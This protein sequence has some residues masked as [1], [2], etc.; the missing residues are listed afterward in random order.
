MPETISELFEEQADRTPEAIA[1][2]LGASQC[3]YREIDAYANQI[4]HVLRSLG[5]GRDVLVGLFLHRSIEMI[6]GMLG[7]LKAGGAYVPL[8]PAYPRQRIEFIARDANLAAIVTAKHLRGEL[9]GLLCKTICL[10]EDAEHISR[11]SLSRPASR[12]A[13]NDLAYVIYTSGSTGTPKGVLIEHRGVVALARAQIS[14]FDVRPDSRVLQLSSICFDASV[15][16]YLMAFATG[17]RL[18]LIRDAEKMPGPELVRLIADQQIT[19]ALLIPSTLAAMPFAPLPSL[20]VIVSAA[21]ACPGALVDRWGPGRKFVNA[22]G[23]TETTVHATAYDCVPGAGAPPIGVPLPGI[24]AHVLDENLQ[25]VPVGEVGEIHIGGISLARGYLGRPEITASRFVMNPRVPGERLYKSGDVGRMLSN[26]VIEYVG[27]LDQQVKIRGYR[28]ELGEIELALRDHPAVREA[29]AVARADAS[30]HKRI[31]AFVVFNAGERADTAGLRQF[32]GRRLPEYMIPAV[33][34][35]MDA[36][37]LAPS[38]KVDR[39]ALPVFNGIRPDTSSP[40]VVPRNAVEQALADIVGGVLGIDRAGCLDD[41]LEVGGDSLLAVRVVGRISAAFGVELRVRDVFLG[42]TIARMA[43]RVTELLSERIESRASGMV[44][45]ER[46][47][48][49][50]LSSAENRLWF[51]HQV[52][53]SSIAY[54][55]PFA[56][57]I[58]GIVDIDRLRRALDEMIRRHESLRT[59]YVDFE[60][61]PERIIAD[62]LLFS[63]DVIDSLGLSGIELQRELDIAWSEMAREA[64][65]LRLGPLFRMRLVRH[66]EHAATLL[67]VFH[68]LI[69]DGRSMAIFVHDLAMLTDASTTLP[70]VP[71]DYADYAFWQR[72]R[73]GAWESETSYWR[74][75]LA[76]AP[77]RS[78]LP[79]HWAGSS[80]S[81]RSAKRSW[82]LPANI[83]SLLRVRAREQ[84]ASLFMVLF[85][86][87]VALL[88]EWTG[89]NDILVGTPTAGR[90]IPE[91]ESVLGFFANTLVLR[92]RFAGVSTF[93]TLLANVRER[94][95][96]AYAHANVPFDKLVEA[97]SPARMTGRNPFF[98]VM[99]ALQ[100]PMAVCTNAEGTRFS[101][102]EGN[103]GDSPFDL[104]WQIWEPKDPSLPLTGEVTFRAD[105]ARDG[106]I[107][108][109]LER[110]TAL[111]EVMANTPDAPLITA[112]QTEV[113][114]QIEWA[115]RIETALR[116]HVGIRDV[117]VLVEEEPEPIPRLHLADWFEQREVLHAKASVAISPQALEDG[118][119][120]KTTALADG[121]PLDIAPDEPQTLP[122]A[123]VRAAQ[124]NRGLIYVEADGT[125]SQQSYAELLTEAR[126]LLAGLQRRG[127]RV[128]DRV[129]LQLGA[130]RAHFVSF[131]ACLLGGIIPVTV[132]VAP[133]Y[134]VSSG[135]TAKLYNVWKLLGKPIILSTGR[136]A[137][138]MAA[139]AN[140]YPGEPFEIWAV[141]EESFVGPNADVHLAKPSDV[142]FLQLS[143]GSTGIPKCI[144]ETHCGV[145]R[146][147]HAAAR[148]NGYAD[149]D[150]TLNWL[151]VDHVVPIL[152]WHLRDVVRGRRQIQAAT[153][154]VL[155]DPLRWLDLLDEFR[156]NETWS[157]NFGFKLVVDR[158]TG[159][160][161]HRPWDLSTVRHF[162]NAG[163]QVTYPVVRDFTEKLARFGVSPRVM[164]PAF[165]MAEVCTCMT[166][167]NDFSLD[168]RVHW[169]DRASLNRAL[170]FVGA[171]QPG[172]TTFVDL[173]PP[174][175]GVAIRITDTKNRVVSEGVIGRLQI[176]GGVVTP[177]YLDNDEANRE[178]FVG[179][180]WF[181]SG[182]LGFIRSGRLT[183]TGREKEIIIVR[184]ANLACYEV[185]DI[186]GS[187]PGV[188][189]TFVA[190]TAVEDVHAGT[191]GLAIFFVPKGK[192]LTQQARV[193]REIRR[194]VTEKLG[195]TPAV[196]V[197]LERATFPKTTSGKIQRSALKQALAGGGFRAILR[198]L[199]L[200]EG[201]RSTIPRWFY[202]KIF[203]LSEP[204]T[205]TWGSGSILLIHNADAR[206]ISF[207]R[208][209]AQSGKTVRV[210]SSLMDVRSAPD[211]ER[212]SE[213][214]V[215]PD[216]Q[217]GVDETLFVLDCIRA[218]TAR[219]ADGSTRLFVVSQKAQ[220]VLPGEKVN[221]DRSMVIGLLQTAAQEFPALECRHVDI[222]GSPDEVTRALLNELSCCGADREIAYRDGR[223][224]VFALEEAAV[225]WQ[226]S[227]TPAFDFESGGVYVI[228][229]GLGGIGQHLA[230]WLLEQF[231]AHLLLLGRSPQS[232]R[233]EVL[234]KLEAIALQRHGSVRYASVDVTQSAALEA[235][236]TN[237]EALWGK[238][239]H[240]VLH[241]A[242]LARTCAIADE[243]DEGMRALLESRKDAV[244]ALARILESRPKTALV[245]FSSV[246][247][248]F[249]GTAVAAYSA[250][251]RYMDQAVSAY[252][253]N[254]RFAANLAFGLWDG[255]G[256]SARGGMRSAAMAS[257]YLP[258]SVS[259]GLTSLRLAVRQGETNVLVGLDGR[260]PRIRRHL[261]V[262]TGL[263][264][265]AL[266]V[267]MVTGGVKADSLPDV[268]A[269]YDVH[270][271]FVEHIPRNSTGNIE[272][273]ALR[274]LVSASARAQERPEFEP[275]GSDLEKAIA[276]IWQKA[277]HLDRIGIDDNFFDVGGH[278]LLL[279]EVRAA[280]EKTFG[281]T[282]SVTDLFGCPTIRLLA[283]FLGGETSSTMTNQAAQR[284]D[285]QRSALAHFKPRPKA[286]GPHG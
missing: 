136:Q 154:Y 246:N 130:L 277:L 31:E 282:I 20:Q 80:S 65:D 55:L 74:V 18:H 107:D 223:R 36:L 129:I 1:L 60:G 62:H 234:D 28:I 119:E 133:T 97:L 190:A 34:I 102:T 143:S 45:I 163:E 125:R 48:P 233:M 174:V 128:G 171:D 32:V 164:Q 224:W 279:A 206:A 160:S 96:G 276:E 42:R 95:L 273:A 7:I 76:R 250:A 281:R 215:F 108:S 41:F 217:S 63:L 155:A 251:S 114:G 115:T 9:S 280:L 75:E 118:L 264:P 141:D 89:Q 219:A 112:Q 209:L 142:A 124:G 256:M 86:G 137:S 43:E 170:E 285:R 145:I 184:G 218:L 260:H 2:V 271:H 267:Y 49:L 261:D 203:R 91:W 244:S 98:Q 199:D 243:T 195:V 269:P 70:A 231:S 148:H 283:K 17:A 278:S 22:Y 12:T 193:V 167:A 23:P 116:N 202:R 168:S 47:R 39:N 286:K 268:Q 38:G 56:L 225:H 94:A 37:P 208:E 67:M 166:Y 161:A 149:D 90:T 239:P 72:A 183:V 227:K 263:R 185:E 77:A 212:F 159:T 26:G 157:P 252:Q 220:Q 113:A 105:M 59:T 126:A 57:A 213:V 187:V 176:K 134:A 265:S 5:V 235:A 156:V 99:F 248:T 179:D 111:L 8:D 204:D 14:L 83:A 85:A 254:D 3:T 222:A 104:F 144:Q 194:V 158:L 188:E 19:H 226:P 15:S 210:A 24:V 81:K 205:R 16:E 198:L 147:V 110:Y 33:F 69:T 4:A 232:E 11:Q 27:R 121:G 192:T 73:L 162:M 93:R 78:G 103:P 253:T 44:R 66:G 216:Q 84:G 51:L 106:E 201:N 87:F 88:H 207:E 30:G 13:A 53:P 127:L 50:P 177:G 259:E 200:Q 120:G 181:N 82:I 100:A 180:G 135:V 175:P 230:A 25:P 117:A 169:V 152:T 132:A 229:G 101:L 238:T 178:A 64:F 257:G 241:L 29:A 236:I 131:W 150:I 173:G 122:E 284:G 189:P 247:G 139:L 35:E 275:A 237:A 211:Q 272:S 140:V 58:E 138:A 165:G 240:A 46:R 21:E 196:V 266:H 191:E 182:D 40:Y 92:T 123:L 146:H 71:L 242:A 52:E 109:L 186:A 61:R 79:T 197:P 6:A 221:P 228:T 274:A 262:E 214:L 153:E 151:P 68:H 258:I 270:V 54:H 245:S 10:D 255:I 172:A 249:G